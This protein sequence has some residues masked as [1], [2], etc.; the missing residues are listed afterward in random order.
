[1]LDFVRIFIALSIVV[2]TLSIFFG[3]YGPDSEFKDFT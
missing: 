3:G 2:L 1:M